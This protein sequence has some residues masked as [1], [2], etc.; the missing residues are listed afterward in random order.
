MKILFENTD[1]F[2]AD[3]RT[4]LRSAIEGQ[5]VDLPKDKMYKIHLGFDEKLI[6]DYTRIE[7]FEI[8]ENALPKYMRGVVLTNKDKLDALLSYQIN[9][10]IKEVE[11][12][13]IL[14]S[15]G[16]I[17]GSPFILMK[18]MEFSLEAYPE[19]E[20]TTKIG[21]KKKNNMPKT[22]VIMPSL[23][24]FANNINN[25]FEKYE[26]RR[27]DNLIKA[28]GDEKLYEKYNSILEKN[29]LYNIYE[30][31]KK[32]YGDLWAVSRSHGKVLRKKFLDSV[33][34]KA[35]FIAD[36]F[37]KKEILQPLEFKLFLLYSIPVFKRTKVNRSVPK[38]I[39]YAKLLTNGRII[40][41]EYEANSKTYAIPQENFKNCFKE[42][43]Q[44]N[45]N[46]KLLKS[47]RDLVE[48]TEQCC[49]EY[50]YV[51]EKSLVDNVIAFMDIK[52]MLKN[53]R[54]A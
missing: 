34:I 3:L 30:D 7:S 24:G 8:P 51:L 45:N 42:I 20:S 29:V 21:V 15:S 5:M 38:Y 1:L 41:V 40:K 32:E 18:N 46:R 52:N 13:G 36:E 50:G 19:D 39:G 28:F 43:E 17:T 35:G 48:Q 2:E 25:F 44:E 47:I 53:A 11:E 23:S 4:K 9:T 14:V 31:F 49:S 16:D 26:K 6:N 54:Q 27:D 33:R 37:E 12:Y 10:V 22:I